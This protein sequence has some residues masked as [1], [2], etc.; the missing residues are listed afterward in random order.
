MR[1]LI[2]E[3]FALFTLF[4]GLGTAYIFLSALVGVSS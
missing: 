2:L 3:F 1:T 4:V